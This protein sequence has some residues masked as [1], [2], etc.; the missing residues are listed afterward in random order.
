MSKRHV[1]GPL[2]VLLFAL[3]LTGCST[4]PRWEFNSHFVGNGEFIRQELTVL[5]QVPVK[6]FVFDLRTEQYSFSTVS[7]SLNT[8]TLT[9]IQDNESVEDLYEAS[10]IVMIIGE[11]GSLV[12][13]HEKV[14]ILL[15]AT[16][17]GISN[18][19]PTGDAS[20]FAAIMAS[21][22]SIPEIIRAFTQL[23]GNDALPKELREK[24]HIY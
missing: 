13:W 11:A 1:L 22:E 8:Q 17:D 6:V 10:D 16:V 19:Q 23:F 24:L 18:D 5:D 21:P 2:L 14:D 12:Y 9:Y 20:F 15:K 7:D 4:E 3:L